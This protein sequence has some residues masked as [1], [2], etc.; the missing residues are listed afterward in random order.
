MTE[1]IRKSKISEDARK[2][3]ISG[4]CWKIKNLAEDVMK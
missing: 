3:K 2:S 1:N 4:K